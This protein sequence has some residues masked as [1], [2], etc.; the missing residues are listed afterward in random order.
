MLLMAG[1]FLVEKKPSASPLAVPAGWGG[2][3]IQLP[4]GFAPDMKL[5]G[6][7]H[8]RYSRGMMNPKRPQTQCL[9]IQTRTRKIE[10]SSSPANHLRPGT[11]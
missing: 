11:P 5:K 1:K 8:I 9:D 2:E 10:N 6:V 3:T 4:P 7:E